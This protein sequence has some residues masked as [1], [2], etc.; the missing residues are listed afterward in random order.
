MKMKRMIII[1][2]LAIVVM[3]LYAWLSMFFGADK[4]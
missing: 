3:V 1:G 4:G 2:D